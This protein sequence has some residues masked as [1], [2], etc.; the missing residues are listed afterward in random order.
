MVIQASLDAAET[1]KRLLSFVGNQPDGSPELLDLAVLLNEVA[2]LT[3]PRWRD[4]TQAEGRPIDLSV[5]TSGDVRTL[6]WPASLREALANL[7][8]NAVDA[9]P[10][11]GTIRL[12]AFPSE[13][14]VVLEVGDS[15]VGMSPDVQKRIFDPFFTTKGERG[16]GLGL[17][18]VA[19]IVERHDGQISVRSAPGRG[20]TFRME[21][22]A[23]QEPVRPKVSPANPGKQPQGPSYRVLAVDDEPALVKMLSF[24]L[25]EAGH[26]TTTVMSAEAALEVLQTQKVDLVIS[27]VGL[28]SGMNGWELTERIRQS[29]PTVPVLLATGW[30]ASI[31]PS[32]A[33]ERGVAGVLSKPY[34]MAELQQLI[35][36]IW[37]PAGS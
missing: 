20:A 4:A 28:G 35:A 23:A 22:P 3:A 37:H 29:W 9:L 26:T 8:F 7:I 25:H 33:Q 16:T 17:A 27:D 30:G 11:G 10:K 21:F 2:H 19:G 34:R 6:G 18:Q 24:M 15:G 12:S 31:D 32:E 13:A 1:V 14:R 36:S 5:E